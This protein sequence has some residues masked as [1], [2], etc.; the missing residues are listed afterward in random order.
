MLQI[1]STFTTTEGRQVILT[2]GAQA[3][4]VFWQVGTLA[5]LGTNSTFKGTIKADQSVTL[6]T[7]SSQ[8]DGA[9]TRICAVT[10]DTGTVKELGGDMEWQ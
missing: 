9:L 2:G 1:A 10:L 6:I 4:N 5:A 8:D 7:G 3:S